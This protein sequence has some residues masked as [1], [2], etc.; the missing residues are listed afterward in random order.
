MTRLYLHGRTETV[1]PVTIPSSRFVRAMCD[2]S[3]SNTLTVSLALPCMPPVQT[4]KKKKYPT[5]FLVILEC[6]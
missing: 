4:K 1:R 5:P 2:P 6:N 3:V